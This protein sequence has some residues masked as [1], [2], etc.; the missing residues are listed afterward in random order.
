MKKF[1]VYVHTCKTNGKKYVGIT[2]ASKPE[3][4]LKEGRG[5]W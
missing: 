3:S 5:Y 1:Y 2:T 4:R